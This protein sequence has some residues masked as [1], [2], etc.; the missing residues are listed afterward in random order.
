MGLFDNRTD[1]IMPPSST[2]AL[3]PG[4]FKARDEARRAEG[5][6][7]N[8]IKMA[9]RLDR[10][11]ARASRKGDARAMDSFIGIRKALTGQGY[12]G[13]G[14]IGNSED[15]EQRVRDGTIKGARARFDIGNIGR[16]DPDG[17]IAGAAPVDSVTPKN[18]VGYGTP[19][20][21]DRKWDAAN[22]QAPAAS[23]IQ[24]PEFAN[25]I[26]NAPQ[27]GIPASGNGPQGVAVPS[28]A[29]SATSDPGALQ[30]RRAAVAGLRDKWASETPEAM[31]V[32]YEGRPATQQPSVLNPRQAFAADLD[33]SQLVETDPAARERAFVRGESLGISR[34][35]IKRRQNW[36]ERPVAL[37]SALASLSMPSNSLPR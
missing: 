8:K 10:N 20:S 33:R 18:R 21:P 6:Q 11:I 25:Q 29:P 7:R 1:E 9:E 13:G 12:G 34:D 22:P 3:Q 15:R 2:T 31:Q 37:T 27:T 24:R 26:S 5:L 14:G 30:R 32:A 16:T 4:G 17:P 35:Q 36:S 28:V 23:P 19:L